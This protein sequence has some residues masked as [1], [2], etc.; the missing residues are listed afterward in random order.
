MFIIEEEGE[1]V[2]VMKKEGEGVNI[3]EEDFAK[4][5]TAIIWRSNLPV[6]DVSTIATCRAQCAFLGPYALLNIYAPSGSN[7]RYERGVFFSQDV[8]NAFNLHPNSTWLVGGD[9]NCVLQPADVENGTGFDQ[10]KCP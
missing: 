1:V 8:F 6:R 9:F 5:G 3:N 10:K 4:P 7:R 2:E